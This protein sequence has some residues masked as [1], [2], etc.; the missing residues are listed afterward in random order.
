MAWATALKKS[1]AD[2]GD[3]ERSS[4][5]FCVAW[6]VW[7]VRYFFY[8]RYIS[9]TPSDVLVEGCVNE[10]GTLDTCNSNVDGLFATNNVFYIN[11][12]GQGALLM[13]CCNIAY[14]LTMFKALN[15]SKAEQRGDNSKGQSTYTTGKHFFVVLIWIAMFTDQLILIP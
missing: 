13:L 4:G 9:C 10:V 8:Y 5:L 14:L 12:L 15:A 1:P 3:E 7:P 2:N 11:M 6:Y